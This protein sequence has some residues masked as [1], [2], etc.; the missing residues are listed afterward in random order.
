MKTR[1]TGHDRN[2]M[3]DKRVKNSHKCCAAAL[4]T[5]RS[6]NRKDLPFHAFPMD[7]SRRKEWKAKMKRQDDK[8]KSNTSLY[9]CG[10]HFNQDDYKR[11][12]TGLRRDLKPNA[13]PSKFPWTENKGYQ[14]LER[15]QRQE[16]R[17]LMRDKLATGDTEEENPDKGAEGQVCV[18]VPLSCH[19][20]EASQSIEE[21]SEL[22]HQLKLQV[23]ISKFGIERFC[24]SDED[25][26][27][28]TGFPNYSTLMACWEYVKPSAESLLTWKHARTKADKKSG[29]PFPYL[30]TNEEKQ[31]FKSRNIQPI[32]QLW[33]FLTRV[34]LGLFERDLA[35]RFQVSVSTVSDILITWTNYLYVML[36]SLPIWVS[37][38]KIYQNL[39]ESFKGEYEDVR[40]IFDCTE[41]KCDMPKDYQTHSELYSDYK[42]HDTYK[43][44]IC[45]SPNGWVTFVSHLF[46]GRISDREIMIKSNFLSL[47]ERGDK[48]LADKG[49]D[50]HDL[51][52]FKGATLYIPP[53]RQSVKDQFTKEEC[54]QTMSIANLRIHVERVICRV[55]GWHIFDQVIPL[56]MHGSINQLWTVCSLLVNFQNPVLTT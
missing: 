25:I 4:C 33:M 37:K 34:R 10:E 27:F 38:D 22:V 29:G 21:L 19:T 11:S 16:S 23:E 17:S 7:E 18:D 30:H 46:P 49:F 55:K 9:C 40:G 56:S 47:V 39:P 24:G 32:D 28:Y 31:R 35:F 15:S 20:A 51:I 2:K 36:G 50:V 54:F 48:Y 52:A 3:A 44:F 26:F 53:K 45:I 43:G 12:L 14:S 13:V 5:N 41:I 6:D 8:F 1:P 42:S